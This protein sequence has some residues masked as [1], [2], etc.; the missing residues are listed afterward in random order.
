MLTEIILQTSNPMTFKLDDVNPDDLVLLKSI[1]GLLPSDVTL[2]RGDFARSGGY[3]QG[4]RVGDRNP[5]FT[6]GLNPSYADDISVS[7]VREMLYRQFYEPGSDTDGVQ[8][9]VRDDRRPDRYFIAYTDKWT[10]DLFSKDTSA[11][12]SMICVDPF[13]YSVEEETASSD[14]GWVSLSVPYDGSADT[15]IEL[16]LNVA[17]STPKIRVMLDAQEFVLERSFSIEDTVEINTVPGQRKITCNGVNIMASLTASS[18]WLNLSKPTQTLTV[19]GGIDSDG[20]VSLT[21]YRYRSA[22][23]GV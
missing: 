10:G 17:S 16:K 6:L 19:D 14:T 3:Y 23:W 12:I 20:K 4:R 5:V 11:Q 22:W 18:K 8:V 9:L 2:F 15:G 1:S 21:E 7:D 13:L